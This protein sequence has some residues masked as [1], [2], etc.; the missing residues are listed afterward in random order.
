LV[1]YPHGL[2]P[3]GSVTNLDAS[4]SVA[5]LEKPKANLYGTSAGADEWCRTAVGEVSLSP[6]ANARRAKRRRASTEGHSEKGHSGEGHSEEVL[7]A[8]GMGAR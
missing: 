3:I 7:P 2:V 4:D 5:V 1:N 6:G 8:L